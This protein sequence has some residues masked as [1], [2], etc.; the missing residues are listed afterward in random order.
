MPDLPPHCTQIDI[1]STTE[2]SS[3]P[4]PAAA[5]IPGGGE[6]AALLREM[7][8]V[9]KRS[10]DILG[11]VLKHVSLQQ[12]QRAAELKAWRENN[13]AVA[14]AC[15]RAAE[16]LAQVHTDF[17]TSLAEEAAENAEDFADSDYALG[18]FIDRYGPRLAHF[19]GVMQLLSQLAMPDEKPTG[20]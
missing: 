16:G 12:R 3:T 9:Q 5:G 17:L 18:D 10:C 11:E 8:A 4:L 2:S 13:P 6:L 20:G 14:R 15:R 1:T 7:L 19:N